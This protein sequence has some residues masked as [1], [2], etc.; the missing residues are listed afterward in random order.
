MAYNFNDIA[1]ELDNGAN[2]EDI[3]K[4]FTDGVNALLKE[5]ANERARLEQDFDD[6]CDML[7]EYWEEA[8]YLY[9]DMGKWPAGSKYKPSHLTISKDVFKNLITSLVE[10]CELVELFQTAV[11]EVRSALHSSPSA[12]K[13]VV[14]PTNDD[15]ANI[16]NNF[17]KEIGIN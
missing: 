10:N 5:R 3:C 11:E 6:C 15:F 12:K 2:I 17:F 4:A 1:S 13:I 14:N 8:L 9:Q 7:A 16:M